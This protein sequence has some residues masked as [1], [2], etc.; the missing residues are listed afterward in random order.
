MKQTELPFYPKRSSIYN[1]IT[2]LLIAITI[3]I[4]VLSLWSIS[5][6]RNIDQ[7]EKHFNKISEQHMVQIQLGLSFVLAHNLSVQDYLDNTA[8]QPWL[9][10]IHWYNPTGILLAKSEQGVEIDDLYGITPDKLDRSAEFIP[11]VKALRREKLEGYVRITVEKSYFTDELYQMNQDNLSLFRL[12]V[13][14]SGIVG[15]LLTR[16][17]NRFSR[18]GFRLNNSGVNKDTEKQ[19]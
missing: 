15:F 19:D 1:K 5:N 14:L 11:F 7:I 4:V 3:I 9:R 18:Q 2:Q 12:I 16:G 10:S 6:Q 17:F 8:Q 13:L